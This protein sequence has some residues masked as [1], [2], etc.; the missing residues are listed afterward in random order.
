[1]SSS[2]SHQQPEAVLKKLQQAKRPEIK[3]ASTKKLLFQYYMPLVLEWL[4]HHGWSYAEVRYTLEQHD[5]KVAKSTLYHYV[6]EYR[7]ISAKATPSETVSGN[8]LPSE[9]R[10]VHSGQPDNGS[11]TRV[12]KGLGL[13]KIDYSQYGNTERPSKKSKGDT[14]VDM[15]NKRV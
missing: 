7:E 8:R 14:M 1:M 5:I 10:T 6:K 3:P 13:P 11:E 15:V 2:Q 12:K 4:D 9:G